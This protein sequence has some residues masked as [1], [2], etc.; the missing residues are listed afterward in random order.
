MGYRMRW[1]ANAGPADM[2][3]ANELRVNGSF[4][5]RSVQKPKPLKDMTGQVCE[6]CGDKISLVVDEDL[7]VAYNE[8]SVRA[9]GDD[10]EEDLDDNEHEFNIDDEQNKN[11]N[12]CRRIVMW[13]D[14][15]GFTQQQ[16]IIISGQ[17][18]AKISFMAET[19][20]NLKGVTLSNSNDRWSWS[21]VGSG[22]FSASSVR[23]LIDNAI[24][25]K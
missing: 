10:D 12:I 18:Y 7:F 15:L 19:C 11:K 2:D 5:S 22:D 14:E 20:S 8:C 1:E 23:K 4:F 9:E 6:I 21:L 24:L 13:E 17:M 3:A 16:T 25:P